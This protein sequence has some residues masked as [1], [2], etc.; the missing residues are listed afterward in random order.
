[1]RYSNHNEIA[2][3]GFQNRYSCNAACTTFLFLRQSR[4]SSDDWGQGLE[5]GRLLVKMDHSFGTA[6]CRQPKFYGVRS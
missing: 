6:L 2:A 4:H 5:A 1:M 3:A